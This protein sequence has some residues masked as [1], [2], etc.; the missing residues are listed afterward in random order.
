MFGR[1]LGELL[2]VLPLGA[3]LAEDDGAQLC[4]LGKIPGID[5]LPHRLAEELINYLQV[6][7]IEHLLGEYFFNLPGIDGS[8][9]RDHGQDY[10]CRQKS[11]NYAF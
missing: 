4:Y 10:E 9:T 5:Q 6:F 7:A 3:L 2:G 1:R 11:R 8:G